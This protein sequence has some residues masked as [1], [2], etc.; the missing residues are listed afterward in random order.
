[1]VSQ[2]V[3]AVATGRYA[4]MLE[5]PELGLEDF[6]IGFDRMLPDPPAD[7]VVR[8]ATVGGVSGRWIEVPES[9]PT[10]LLHMHAGGFMI[11]SSYSHR[12]MASRIARAAGARVFL[13]DYRLAPE[14]PYP[15][16]LDDVL[17]AYRGLLAEGVSPADLVISGDSAG[18]GLAAAAL[19][20]LRDAGDP[21]PAAGVLL[22]PWADLTLTG[23]SMIA[24]ESIDPLVR[25]DL[26][27]GMRQA[28]A[29]EADKADVR[30]SAV[31]ADY[32][33]IPPLLVQVGSTEVLLDDSVRIV[34]RALAAG[35]RAELQVGY[36]MVHVY[37]MFA[38]ELPE[39]QAAIERIG[40][41]LRSLAPVPTGA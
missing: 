16:A 34:D 2:R 4:F 25:K 27:E 23:D 41:F 37:Q 40:T 29:A 20:A 31:F 19:I 28:Y 24:H 36:E 3:N 38:D 5:N 15:A 17:A 9:G 21:L 32:T 11:G 8:E 10:T 39:A 7:V 22:S 33:G 12:E 6:R 18:G 13:L 35:V 1:M 30:L 14:N 26:L